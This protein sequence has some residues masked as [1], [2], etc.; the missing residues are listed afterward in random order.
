[1]ALKKYILT[2]EYNDNG[3]N[4]EYIQE[5]IVD[6]SPE[7][8]TVGTVDLEEYFSKSEITMLHHTVIGKA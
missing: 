8:T 2:I 6:D 3:D 7:T 1:M 4:C 5:E